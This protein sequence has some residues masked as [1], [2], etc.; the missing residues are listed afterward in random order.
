MAW[1]GSPTAVTACPVAPGAGAEEAGQQQSLGDGGVLVLVEQDDAEFVAQDPA[2]FGAGGGEGRAVGDLVAEVEQVAAAFLGAVGGDEVEQFQAAAG[3]FGD[4]AQ[5]GVGEFHAVEGGEQ[6]GVV[7]AERGGVHEVLGELGV[8]GEEV[9]HE[10]G[11]GGG[12]RRVGAGGGAQGAGGELEAGGV[13]EEPG[14]GLQADAQAVVLEE[15]AGEGVVG[16]DPRLAGGLVGG[17]AGGSGGSASGSVTPA[18]RSADLTRSAS[19]PAALFVNVS[20]RTCSGATWPVPTS[21][22]TRA[23]ITVVLPEP[24]PATMTCGAGGAVM[25]SVCSGVNG[26]P[27][28]SLSCSGSVRRADTAK[29]VTVGTD[30]PL[31][32]AC[33]RTRLRRAAD[34]AGRRLGHGAVAVPWPVAVH[35]STTCRPSGWALHDA[36]KVQWAQCVP[37]VGVNR[38]SSTRPAAVASSSPTHSPSASGCCACT[39]GSAS[40]PSFWAAPSRRWTSSAPPGSGRAAVEGLVDRAL[41][42]RELVDGELGVAGDLGAGRFRFA[43][44]EVDDVRPALRVP[45]DV[46]HAAPD[47]HLVRAGLEGDVEAVLGGDGLPAAGLALHDVPA[48]EAL[49][50]G[51]RGL[52]LL[53]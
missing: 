7:G 35:H 20:P 40:P 37:V 43:G 4:L 52:L 49:Q 19:S 27:R 8:Q 5:V 32:W 16:G 38:S 9:L 41:A 18:A 44:L 14:A 2:D 3:G 48:Q 25:H 21:H 47:A 26:M 29:T 24:A 30:N 17:G 31:R 39:A 10:G 22:T 15:L 11:Q 45:A 23:A 6:L 33:R 53:A 34:T 36:R 42:H 51:A 46:V 12:E 50:G 28:S 1:Q 13:G